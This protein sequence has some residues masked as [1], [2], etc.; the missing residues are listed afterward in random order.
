[1]FYIVMFD[2]ANWKPTLQGLVDSIVM[3]L[4][5]SCNTIIDRILLACYEAIVKYRQA[6]LSLTTRIHQ[7]KRQQ[8]RCNG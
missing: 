6:T 4:F 3:R 2:H 5:V 7:L 1:M 8:A